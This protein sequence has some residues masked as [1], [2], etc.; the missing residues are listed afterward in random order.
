[1]KE[2]RNHSERKRDN[3]HP[4]DIRVNNRVNPTLEKNLIRRKEEKERM[5]AMRVD[6]TVKGERRIR[7]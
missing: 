6:R 7:T 5:G 4:M 2:S 1:M 3:T